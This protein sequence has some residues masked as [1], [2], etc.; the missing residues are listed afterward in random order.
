MGRPPGGSIGRT[1]A[2]S[3]GPDGGGREGRQRGAAS[4][5]AAEAGWRGGTMHG[6]GAAGGAAAVG[7]QRSARS[8]VGGQR[9]ARSSPAAQQP[10]CRRSSLRRLWKQSSWH[11]L[12]CST[13][14]A[15]LPG[16]RRLTTAPRPALLPPFPP[17]RRTYRAHGRINA[18]M[19]S[20]CHIEL[21][22][23]ER[24]QA[25]KG[26][27]VRA[28]GGWLVRGAACVW[29]GLAIGGPPVAAPRVPP[30]QRT[31]RGC[32]VGWSWQRVAGNA[33]QQHALRRAAAAC[34][35]W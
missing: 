9:S 12:A 18:Y 26:E 31:V 29:G 28:R 2:C 3:G 25:V 33:A 16:T 1:G 7:G 22:L 24:E 5:C 11:A 27:A 13:P 32:A 34:A 20:P 8:S 19:S 30:R 10:S 17:D 35:W 21:I 6:Q 4:R 23:A 15:G 14:R